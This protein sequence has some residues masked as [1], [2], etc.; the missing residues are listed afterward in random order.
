[1]NRLTVLAGGLVVALALPLAGCGSSERNLNGPFGDSATSPI[2]AQCFMP[3][4]K[5][6]V[7]TLGMLSFSNK[8]DRARIDK[9]TLVG[10]RNLQTVAE[11][12]VPITGHNLLGVFYGYPP[13]GSKRKGFALAPGVQWAERQHADG[14]TIGHMP[15]P[16]AINLVLVLKV[17]GGVEGTAKTVYLDYESGGTKYRLNFQVAIELWNG[18]P[19]RCRL[20]VN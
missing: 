16:E 12:V 19:G 1:V 10:A 7:A 2:G 18:K 3:E 17:T 6:A 5:G 4:P 14:A 9:V 11:W 15:F 13:Y 20:T 8:G